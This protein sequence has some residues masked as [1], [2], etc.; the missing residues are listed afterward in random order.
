ATDPASAGAREIECARSACP[1]GVQSRE[2]RAHN[3]WPARRTRTLQTA[4]RALHTRH[5]HERIPPRRGPAPVAKAGDAAPQQTA[6]GSDTI[7]LYHRAR[8]QTD[9]PCATPQASPDHQCSTS[10]RRRANLTC[11]P[12]CW[13]GAEMRA[14]VV[15]NEPGSLRRY[16]PGETGGFRETRAETSHSHHD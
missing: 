12:G 13:S 16:T 11:A 5:W 9:W 6:R 14:S 1:P 2:Q 15:S 4:S 10:R 3:L 8:P 7:R